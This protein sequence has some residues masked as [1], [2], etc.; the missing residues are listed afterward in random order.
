MFDLVLFIKQKLI[1]YLST[2]LKFPYQEGSVWLYIAHHNRKY[3]SFSLIILLSR[4]FEMLVKIDRYYR[5][6]NLKHSQY[7]NDATQLKNCI[8]L[9]LPPCFLHRE[10]DGKRLQFQNQEVFQ[11]NCVVLTLTAV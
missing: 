6:S 3:F 9:K 8:G 2:F 1:C 7:K 11:L 4:H 5:S 10:G